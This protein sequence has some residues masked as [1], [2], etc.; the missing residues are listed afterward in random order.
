MRQWPLI[1]HQSDQPISGFYRWK[2]GYPKQDYV[3]VAV[4]LWWGPPIDRHT[5]RLLDR[6]E[7]WTVISNG[8]IVDSPDIWDAWTSV[9]GEPITA[10]EYRFLLRRAGWYRQYEPDHPF[11]CPWKRI[12]WAKLS[13]TKFRRDMV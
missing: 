6:S 10:H 11:A 1:V 9:M 7:R 2:L 3:W 13:A 8:C 12:E 4:R 5:P